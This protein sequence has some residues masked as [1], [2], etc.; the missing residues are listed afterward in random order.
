VA[1]TTICHLSNDTVERDKG[2]QFLVAAFSER[3]SRCIRE[4]SPKESVH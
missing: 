4:C 3:A 2:L 1:G